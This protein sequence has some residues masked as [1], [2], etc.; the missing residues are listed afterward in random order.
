MNYNCIS[1]NS[2]LL[3]LTVYDVTFQVSDK[4]SKFCFILIF[5]F[6]LLHTEGYSA[7]ITPAY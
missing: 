3:Q 6:F 5:S 2:L 7:H 4:N 1:G